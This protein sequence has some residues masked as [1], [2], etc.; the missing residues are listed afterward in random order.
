MI[1][2]VHTRILKS[3]TKIARTIGTVMMS[4]MEGLVVANGSSVISLIIVAIE[5]EITMGV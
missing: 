3:T 1:T 4:G 5:S 2:A